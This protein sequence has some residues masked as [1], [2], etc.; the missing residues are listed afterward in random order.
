[1]IL[2]RVVD[3]TGEIE[4]WIEWGVP[5]A[6]HQ[7]E[8][9]T[10]QDIVVPFNRDDAPTHTS[11]FRWTENGPKWVE[12]ASLEQLRTRK[13]EAINAWKLEANNTYFEF[14][15]KEIAYKESDRVEIQAINNVVL[16]T[17]AMPTHPDWPGAWK[18]IDNEW[19]PLPDLAAWTAFNVAVADRGTAHFKR[20]QML[21]AQLA[22]AATPA[23]IEAITW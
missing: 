18:A 15:G 14:G 19:V 23:Q 6:L 20:S 11:E 10:W 17:G 5:L 16:L 2:G 21:K 9:R 7:I 12:T 1:M 13:N 22:A 8:G 4:C 3:A